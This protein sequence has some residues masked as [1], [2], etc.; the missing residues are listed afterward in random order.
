MTT[1]PRETVRQTVADLL[2]QHGQ[3]PAVADDASLFDS[4]RLDSMSAVKIMLKLEADFGL[5][6]GD[7]DFDIARLDT[8]DDIVAMLDALAP[9]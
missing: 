9:A 2:R 1:T 7:P 4:G 6:L 8:I 3:D 5:D